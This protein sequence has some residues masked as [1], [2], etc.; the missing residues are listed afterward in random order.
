MMFCLTDPRDSA[1]VS[2]Y[3]LP[4]AYPRTRPRPRPRP[5]GDGGRRA[6]HSGG[7][8]AYRRSSSPFFVDRGHCIRMRDISNTPASSML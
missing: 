2:F 4:L 6:G 5:G 1:L 7:S 3:I 8:A